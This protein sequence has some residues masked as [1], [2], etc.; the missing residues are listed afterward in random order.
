MSSSGEESCLIYGWILTAYEWAN[1]HEPVQ[2]WKRKRK[3][4]PLKESRTLQRRQRQRFV[5]Q[6]ITTQLSVMVLASS[7]PQMPVYTQTSPQAE[8]M[9]QRLNEFFT[10]E[11]M[12]E[13][14]CYKWI[15]DNMG[16][17]KSSQSYRKGG[18]LIKISLW[19]ERKYTGHKCFHT[20]YISS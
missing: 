10:W 19:M 4:L 1:L 12:I 7:Q 11:Q 13:M 2:G 20:W 8:I 6:Q 3:F 18:I 15:N 17:K 14:C 9:L 5:C 16:V